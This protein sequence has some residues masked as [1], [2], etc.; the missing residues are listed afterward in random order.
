MLSTSLESDSS[1]PDSQNL[2][3]VQTLQPQGNLGSVV[4]SLPGSPGKKGILDSGRTGCQAS[5]C[6]V[7][8]TAPVARCCPGPPR[9]NAALFPSQPSSPAPHPMRCHSALNHRR[10]S[11]KV[12]RRAILPTSFPSPVQMNHA[13]S[14]P[15]LPCLLRW[16]CWS[17]CLSGD[18]TCA[19][20]QHFPLYL[21][22]LFSSPKVNPAFDILPFI[23][24]FQSSMLRRS[25]LLFL[26]SIPH[27]IPKFHC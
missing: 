18:T 2:T 9:P 24:P 14:F 1:S 23:P 4:F 16:F 7:S 19:S 5:Q 25:H 17:V 13:S 8:T 26:F 22:N 15:A 20:C 12:L 10:I 11:P 21:I 27:S 3:H 6:T